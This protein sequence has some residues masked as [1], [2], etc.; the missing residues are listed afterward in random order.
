[1]KCLNVMWQ[2][3]PMLWDYCTLMDGSGPKEGRATHQAATT[4]ILDLVASMEL[5]SSNLGSRFSSE[6]ETPLLE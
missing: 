1:M 3:S 6:F 4:S 5:L 2:P